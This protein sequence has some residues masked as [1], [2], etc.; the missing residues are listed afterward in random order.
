MLAQMTGV[1]TLVWGVVWIGMGAAVSWW[2]FQ[3]ALARA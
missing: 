1:P 2:L 3:R